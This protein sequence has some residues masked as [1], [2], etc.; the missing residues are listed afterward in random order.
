MGQPI[1][2]VDMDGPLADFDR[3][4]FERC[5]ALGLT[6][7]CTY[8]TQRHRF[9]S[10]HIPD[11]FQRTASRHMVNTSGWFRNLPVTEGAVAGLNELAEHAEVWICTKPLE[12]NV[13][14]RDEKAD[15]LAEH[16]GSEWVNRLILAPD[17]SLVLG[18]VLLDDAPHPAWYERSA[19][20]PVIFTMTWNGDGSKWGGLPH[21]SWGDPIEQLLEVAGR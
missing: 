7:D 16:F 8:A 11:R 3:H 1:F 4:F 15:W 10:D 20:E 9:A 5:E 6:F 12:A 21:W 13:T 2:L 17:K 18:N 19:W 14:C